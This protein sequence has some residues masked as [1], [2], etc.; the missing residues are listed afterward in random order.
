MIGLDTNILLRFILRDDP[1]QYAKAE[2]LLRD[3]IGPGAPGYISIVVLVEFAWTL[4]RTAKFPNEKIRETVQKLLEVE[5]LVFERAMTVAH[6][7]AISRRAGIDVPD[8]LIA[9][10]GQE[11]GCTATLTFDAPFAQS[12]EAEL[13]V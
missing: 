11:D 4:R 12:G 5:T 1:I 2:R 13:L 6:A 7:L 3:R 10:I 8:A 9:A